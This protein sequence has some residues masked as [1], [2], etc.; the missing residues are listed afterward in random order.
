MD[1]LTALH[2][3][4]LLGLSILISNYLLNLKVF[5]FPKMTQVFT[6]PP[7]LSVLIPARNEEFRLSPCLDTLGTN[8]YPNFEIL[9]LNDHSQDGTGRSSIATPSATLGFAISRDKTCPPVGPEK[10]GPATN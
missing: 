2:L 3:A 6:P 9:V 7:L 8:D 1:F 5:R 4:I 10:R